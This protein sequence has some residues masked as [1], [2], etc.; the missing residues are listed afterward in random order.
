VG[1]IL[2]LVFVD[3]LLRTEGLHNPSLRILTEDDQLVTAFLLQPKGDVAADAS[4]VKSA[5]SAD[6]LQKVT[7]C[8]NTASE[9]SADLVMAP[10]YFCPWSLFE[11]INDQ[12]SPAEGMLWALCMNSIKPQELTQLTQANTH[13]KWIFDLPAA[14][15]TKF[16]N[17]MA[18]IFRTQESSDP[19]QTKT[20]VLLQFK[21]K[22]MVDTTLQLERRNLLL[23]TKIYV[24]RN[25]PN[26]THL[27]SIICSDALDFDPTSFFPQWPHLPHILLHPQLNQNPIHTLFR[28]YRTRWSRLLGDK[29]Q[30]IA[31]NW[32]KGTSIGGAASQA[33]HYGR[34]C[35]YTKDAHIYTRDDLNENHEQGFY[36]AFDKQRVHS[37]YLNF[38]EFVYEI[39]MSKVGRSNVNAAS[40]NPAGPLA[41]SY[42]WSGHRWEISTS[43]DDGYDANCAWLVGRFPPLTAFNPNKIE[44]EVLINRATGAFGGSVRSFHLVRSVEVS[45]DEEIRRITFAQDLSSESRRYRQFVNTL[46]RELCTSVLVHAHLFPENIAFCASSPRLGL[47]AEFFNLSNAKNECATVCYLGEVPNDQVDEAFAEI[48]ERVHSSDRRKIC[49]WFKDGDDI[50][51]KVE[52]DTKICNPLQDLPTDYTREA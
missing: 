51:H 9:R 46:F 39:Q 19:A 1:G 6:A 29:K 20:V 36:Y 26:S 31:V 21:T 18:Y 8:L 48:C 27:A 13:L 47:F 5:N 43:V 37:Y 52:V 25:A 2:D 14:N 42:S 17:P 35:I 11:I 33:E 44:K 16:L 4:G 45:G 3:D 38:E 7:S 40:A 34:S 30:I 28:D 22:C 32:A 15:S 23:G 24:F 10:E 12:F 49:I 50:K 41:T